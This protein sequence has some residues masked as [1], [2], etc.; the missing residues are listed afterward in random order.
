LDIDIALARGATN[1]SAF[2]W[3]VGGRLKM[4]RG[5]TVSVC[6]LAKK[7]EIALL[8]TRKWLSAAII[9]GRRRQYPE[10]LTAERIHFFSG[11]IFFDE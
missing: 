8:Q 4:S 10:V 3:M 11:V 5:D 1:L 7:L 9:F 2:V 6:R